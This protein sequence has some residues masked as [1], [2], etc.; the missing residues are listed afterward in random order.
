MI[1]HTATVIVALGA[2]WADWRPT[3][4]GSI[5]NADPAHPVRCHWEREADA[6][7]CA[8]VLVYAENAWIEQ[9]DRIGFAPPF[10][11]DD[12]RVDLYITNDY[13]GGGAYTYAHPEDLDAF[14]GRMASAAYVALDWAVPD[15][16]MASYVAHEFNHVLQYATDYAEPTLPVWEGTAT[17]AQTWTLGDFDPYDPYYIAHFQQIPWMGILG[18]GYIAWD[19]YGIYSFH[20][21]GSAAW[22][23]HLDH[24]WGDDQGA[25]AQAM[26]WEL[27]QPELPNEPDVL[28]ALDAVT[29]SWRDE[30]LDFTVE[31]TR[32]G[33][34]AHPAWYGPSTSAMQVDV[35]ST[36]AFGDLPVTV[37][38]QYA[39]YPTGSVYV[40]LTG[41][42]AGQSVRLSA[43]AGAPVDWGLVAVEGAADARVIADQLEWE[44][45]G[46]TVLF[47]VLHLASGEWDA[48]DRLEPTVVELHLE[49]VDSVDTGDTGAPPDTEDSGE[50]T[51]TGGEQD[52]DEGRN[53]GDDVVKGCGCA[54]ATGGGGLPAAALMGAALLWRRRRALS[55]RNS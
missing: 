10:P 52:F 4:I 45:S 1:C 12:G 31:R 47:A 24:Y 43:D 8:D 40:A 49:A 48:D 33:T 50:P 38:P 25:A 35:D 51:D 32:I 54:G 11:D 34:A 9:V 53:E 18:D 23:R 30:L 16:E 36:V 44:G 2:Y 55:K 29:G 17:A 15:D 5:D 41:L 21:Y 27:A 6:D 37:V 20:E 7:R 13:T 46:E 22:V 19:D 14:D 28:D 3:T 42:P 26:W 39:P